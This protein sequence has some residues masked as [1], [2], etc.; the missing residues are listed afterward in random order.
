MP[1]PGSSSEAIR[2]AA[3]G[4]SPP[5]LLTQVF[6]HVLLLLVDQLIEPAKV[7]VIK[8]ITFT[9]R[10]APS[11]NPYTR[12]EITLRTGPPSR[13]KFSAFCCNRVSGHYGVSPQV[14]SCRSDGAP[15]FG[16]VLTRNS[17]TLLRKKWPGPHGTPASW[18]PLMRQ[19]NSNI[20]SASCPKLSSSR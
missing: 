9:L 20:I 13:L 6:D 5:L 3:R 18:A 12:S 10:I 8:L 1:H 11:P 14:S 4:S 2:Q 7:T 15:D 16:P 19:W 17:T